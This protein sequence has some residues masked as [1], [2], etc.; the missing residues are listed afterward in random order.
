MSSSNMFRISE[1]SDHVSDAS[2]KCPST[3]SDKN[4]AGETDN[5]S[6]ASEKKPAPV[7]KRKVGRPRFEEG[8]I[9]TAKPDYWKNNYHE[10]RTALIECPVCGQMITKNNSSA[11]KKTM[12][13]RLKGLEREKS[14]K[15]KC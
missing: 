8:I 13:C 7:A 10:K 2:T 4:I 3:D 5:E 14:M 12:K 11:H 6:S 1:E 9:Q 15:C